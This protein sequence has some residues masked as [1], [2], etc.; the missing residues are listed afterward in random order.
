[1][2]LGNIGQMTFA[3]GLAV[4][5][6]LAIRVFVIPKSTPSSPHS[7]LGQ[8]HNI[9]LGKMPD[10]TNIEDIDT[11]KQSFF[12]YLRPAIEAQNQIIIHERQFLLAMI[13]QI[14]NGIGLNQTDTE[15]LQSIINK[16]QYDIKSL[17]RTTLTPL[18]KRIDTIPVNMVLVQAANES[19][20]GSSRFAV[21]GNNFFGQWC[22]SQG[23]GLVP[24]ARDN[25]KNHEVAVFD[26]PKDSIIA[27][28][29]NLNT[30]QAYRLFRSIRADLRAQKI[31]PTAEKLVFGLINYSERKD[32]YIDELLEM[33]KHNKSFLTGNQANV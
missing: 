3:L 16:Y 17:T 2:K 13:E 29:I 32:E 15:R 7:A 31:K 14:D 9:D 12:D 27:Y 8:L 1:M 10:F 20:W 30:N 26:S 33:L 28:M 25:G 23:C 11:K 4:I 19:G 18:L 22:F 21:E 5:A 24:L 6:L